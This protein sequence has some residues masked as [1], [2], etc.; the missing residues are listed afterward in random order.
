MAANKRKRK[1][2]N[3]VRCP[4]QSDENSGENSIDYDVAADLSI[5]KVRLP[6][7]AAPASAK[8]TE[9]GESAAVRRPCRRCP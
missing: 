2:Q 6:A 7:Q 9:V 1:S 5:K 4:V 8:E 3:P